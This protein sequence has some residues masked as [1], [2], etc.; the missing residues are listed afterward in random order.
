[1]R[2]AV[3][4]ACPDL[5][6]RCRA[7]STRS[8]TPRFGRRRER[9]EPRRPPS[10]D[11]RDESADHTDQL[12]SRL[13]TWQPRARV[14]SVAR[15]VAHVDVEGRFGGFEHHREGA[16]IFVPPVHFGVSVRCLPRFRPEQVLGE[17]TLRS[18]RVR[19][20]A[21]AAAQSESS[22]CLF[23]GDSTSRGLGQR[24]GASIS[25]LRCG[26]ASRSRL[27]SDQDYGR[28]GWRLTARGKRPQ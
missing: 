3:N 1:M 26:G 22:C 21:S 17:P 15:R 16:R 25:A 24:G 11:H 6:T 19:V 20:A 18:G 7:A 14:T 8:P 5:T 9:A 2:D 4:R 28:G 23:G 13:R 12:A 27:R 10:G